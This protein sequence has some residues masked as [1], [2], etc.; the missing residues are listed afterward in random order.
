M[1]KYCVDKVEPEL[2]KCNSGIFVY[3]LCAFNLGFSCSIIPVKKVFKDWCW[4]M[5]NALCCPKYSY[6][7]MQMVRVIGPLFIAHCFFSSFL[8][9]R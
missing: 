5:T 6:S 1:K 8:V 4:F 7:L 9:S 2:Q 3:V